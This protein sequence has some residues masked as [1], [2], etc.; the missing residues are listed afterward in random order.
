MQW[1]VREGRQVWMKLRDSICAFL[2]VTWRP[3]LASLADCLH[4][5]VT[6]HLIGY[7]PPVQVGI[8]VLGVF[9]F[10]GRATYRYSV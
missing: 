1:K 5:V 10:I 6:R 3:H 8:F 7:F 2:H 9:W 4:A